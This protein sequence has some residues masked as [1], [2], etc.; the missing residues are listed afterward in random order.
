[1]TESAKFS[2]EDIVKHTHGRIVSTPA[3]PDPARNCNDAAEI[4]T[5]SRSIA[6]GAIYLPLKGER[7]DGHD[8]V[9]DAIK[10]GA[11]AAIVNSS[12]VDELCSAVHSRCGSEQGKTP[13]LIAVDDTLQAYHDLARAWRQ[14]VD[15]FVVAV[16]G[17]SGKT[18]TKEM[19]ASVFS[20]ARR[21]HK[22][23]K[24]ENNEF[25]VPKTILSMPADA[26]ILVCELAMR[27]LN[28]IDQLA[29]TCSPDV[30]IITCAGTAHIELLGSRENIARAKC[31]LLKH[32]VAGGTAVLGSPTEMLLSE[33]FKVFS[34]KL[35]AFDSED[36][37]EL[38]V[39][40]SGTRF[41]VHSLD[42]EFFVNS[43]GIYHIQDA[44]CAVMA[45]VEAGL[46]HE[47]ISLGLATY[48]QVKGRGNI[49]ITHHGA[50]LVDES[51]NANPDSV[52]CAVEGV[53][54]DRAF[55]QKRKIV[56]LG[57]M[58][59]LGPTSETLH[60]EVGIWIKDKPIS[61]LVTVGEKAAVIGEAAK[62][63]GIDVR[64]CRDIPE[65]ANLVK[66]Q[67]NDNACV[68]VKGSNCA[69]LYD[70]VDLLVEG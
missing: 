20:K 59:E 10:A 40:A 6:H 16:T 65:A 18:T 52:R 66:Q 54:D 23:Q 58:A 49:L 50:V 34:G 11:K 45:G 36:V 4:T 60:H 9:V 26:E 13:M 38:Q 48:T 31:E 56:V 63:S 14:R 70:L 62:G 69:R 57:E 53:V 28:Q 17:S 42:A 15:P 39:T 61:L 35:R 33:A 5:D 55:P 7:F 19:C 21:T 12:R 47:Q 32:I 41:R 51:Y 25:G 68:M 3:Q 43:H 44:W 22:S 1:M 46:S 67:L 2:I 8:F 29:A 37:V 24:N 64:I 30:G 27:G